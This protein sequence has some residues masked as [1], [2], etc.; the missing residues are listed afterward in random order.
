MAVDHFS[1]ALRQRIPS[2][3]Y[4]EKNA[5]IQPCANLYLLR[6]ATVM[7]LFSQYPNINGLSIAYAILPRLRLD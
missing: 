1:N 4:S 6:H 3:D 5:D 7:T 2:S